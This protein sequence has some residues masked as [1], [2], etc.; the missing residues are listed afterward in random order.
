ML[1]EFE[2]PWA[3]RNVTLTDPLRLPWIVRGNVSMLVLPYCLSVE[4]HPSNCCLT[5]SV[6]LLVA[7]V[8]PGALPQLTVTGGVVENVNVAVVISR[9][10]EVEL[11]KRLTASL[12]RWERTL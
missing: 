5:S 10:V 1:I 11:I 7:A 8:H 6:R 12:I 9:G 3:F 4:N 2:F